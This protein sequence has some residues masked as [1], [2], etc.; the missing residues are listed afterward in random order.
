MRWDSSN[1]FA[2]KCT[3]KKFTRSYCWVKPQSSSRTVQCLAHCSS[4]LQ[5]NT[6]PNYLQILVNVECLWL[7]QCVHTAWNTFLGILFPS[8]LKHIILKHLEYYL[9]IKS[10]LRSHLY[11]KFLHSFPFLLLSKGRWWAKEGTQK[12][13]LRNI[14]MA[15]I[16]RCQSNCSYIQTAFASRTIQAW[17][18]V[19]SFVTCLNCT[20][21]GGRSEIQSHYLDW[22]FQY[23]DMLLTTI[24]QIQ[25][26]TVM[27]QYQH[28][29][30][31]FI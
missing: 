25:E 2:S 13:Y 5:R 14:S 10:G 20:A 26:V 18:L 24:V 11:L 8:F 29:W 22:H 23:I 15:F 27:V 9:Y 17:W 3:D 16:D 31:N 7:I 6:W 30:N 21:G 19:H 4:P 12:P 1:Y 28:Y